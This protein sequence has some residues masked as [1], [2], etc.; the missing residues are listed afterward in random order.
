MGKLQ[1][2]VAIVTGATAG[3]GLGIVEVYVEEG[4]NVVFCG[5]REELG[6]SIEADLRAKGHEVTFVKAD[7]LKEEDIRNL[8][9]TAIA[10]YG[11]VDILVNNAGVLKMVPMIDMDV[12]RDWD[13]VINLNLR[14]Y[15]VATQYAAKLMKPGSSIINISSIGGLAG[16]PMLA[17]YGASKAAVISLTKTC[18]VELAPRGIRTNAILPGT[19]F[20]EMM[21]RDSEFTKSTLS[22]IPMGRGGEP[23]EIGTVAAFLASEEASYIC[24]AAIVVDGGMT[25]S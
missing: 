24:G 8:F 17:S 14:S 10:K 11:K 25:A 9:D 5:R 22:M 4:A 15:F 18:G 21:P 6:S 23:R 13:S 20:S 16:S 12:E 1:D 2:K 19:I 7:M 3:I